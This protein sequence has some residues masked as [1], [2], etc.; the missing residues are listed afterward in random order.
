MEHRRFHGGA[1]G[2]G[3]EFGAVAPCGMD[4]LTDS[5]RFEDWQ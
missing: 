4:C 3:G 1:I 2:Y 5:S